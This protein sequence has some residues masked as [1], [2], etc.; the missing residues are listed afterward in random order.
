VTFGLLAFAL[1]WKFIA[2]DAQQVVAMEWKRVLESPLS[3]SV[4]REI[5]LAAVPV[6]S[7]INFIEGI[8][9]VIWTPGFIVLEGTF[10]L[11]R[12][13]DMAVADGGV[14]RTYKKAELLGPAE[15]GGTHVGLV[16][17]SLVLLG[18]ESDLKG[19]IDRSEKGKDS[20]PGGY[21][22]W[23]RTAVSGI[24]RHE[25]GLRLGH[26]NVQITSKLLYTSDASARAA[27]ENA[28]AFGLTG[29]QSG[30]ET[31]LT[32]SPSRDEFTR[33]E[34]RSAI[35]TLQSSKATPVESSKP[36]V[37]RIYG[38]DEGVK[39]IPLK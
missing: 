26:E 32:G 31:F 35:E 17:S 25:F 5:P 24:K 2:P 12:L 23:I 39:E 30:V 19:A 18:S 1:A 29:R 34:W 14:V 27:A 33:R 13:K 20:G 22:L 16:S 15:E 7:S 21:D 28:T 4:R 6:L 10:D 8:E 37:I 11:Q 36:G 9:R 3:A 38:L